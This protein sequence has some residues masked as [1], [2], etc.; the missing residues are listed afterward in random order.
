MEK[1]PLVTIA[2]C[3]YKRPEMVERCLRSLFVQDA[4]FAFDI[5]VVENDVARG[6]R[7]VIEALIL[8]AAEK[9]IDL[10]YYCEPEQNI[11]AARNRCVAE[12]RGEFLAFLDDDEWTEKDWVQ[13]LVDVQ[14]ETEADAVC[15]EVIPVFED[16]F[17]LYIQK[18]VY[19]LRAVAEGQELSRAPT[20]VIL[21]RKTLFDLRK[22]VF[23][24]AFGKTGSEDIDFTCFIVTQQKRIVK[25]FR[26]KAY[27]IQPLSRGKMRFYWER[28]FRTCS[29]SAGINRKYYGFLNG[30]LVNLRLFLKNFILF[31]I[32]LPFLLTFQKRRF[33]KSGLDAAAC[34]GFIAYIFGIKKTGYH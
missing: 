6:S 13:N 23:D 32:S 2:V 1:R 5:V 33:F 16:G 19:P 4:F 31:G 30:T 25:T 34:L 27:E 21:F 28:V 22:P 3:T 29:V 11:S 26:A 10:R 18:V 9:G 17:P 15:G 24:P 20:G 8:E 7:A 14:R 12:C